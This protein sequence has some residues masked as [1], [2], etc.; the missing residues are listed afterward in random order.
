MS[1]YFKNNAANV[2]K[3]KIL[4]DKTPAHLKHEIENPSDTDSE[5]LIIGR[6]IHAILFESYAVFA[7]QFGILPEGHGATKEVKDAKKAIIDAGKTPISPKQHD[8]IFSLE[9]AL[10]SNDTIADL[11]S[12]GEGEKEIYGQLDGVDCKAK[13]DWYRNGIIVDLKTVQD[14][15]ASAIG[16]AKQ[17]VNYH[18][19]LQAYFYQQLARNCGLDVNHFVFIVVEK[20]A[21]FLTATFIAN[22]RVIANGRRKAERAL[23]LWS[24]CHELNQWQGYP[25]GI[26]EFDLP[27]WAEV[28]Y[29]SE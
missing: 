13:L 1:D 3:L 10:K 4:L 26:Q 23:K 12:E 16:F 21:P 25:L 14:G 27:A 19:D 24:E 17:V 28:S 29:D 2:S 22:D 8:L 15:V 9:M 7:D 18:Y 6:A 11:L 5:C 20:T